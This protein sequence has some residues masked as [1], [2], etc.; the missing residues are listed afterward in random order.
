LA[1][2]FNDEYIRVSVVQA[3]D[4]SGEE[5]GGVY[6]AVVGLELQDGFILTNDQRAKLQDGLKVLV[7]EGSMASGV[8]LLVEDSFLFTYIQGVGPLTADQD[9]RVYLGRVA[10]ES[11]GQGDE[12][13]LRAW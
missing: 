4:F 2:S 12:C 10:V 11:R 1:D 3:N 6:Q 9:G 13:V 7:I 5:N 8:E